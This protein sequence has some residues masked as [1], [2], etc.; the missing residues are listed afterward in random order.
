MNGTKRIRAVHKLYNTGVIASSLSTELQLTLEGR[1]GVPVLRMLIRAGKLCL[2]RW[3]RTEGDKMNAVC[4]L[5]QHRPW[6]A[7]LPT[8]LAASENSTRHGNVSLR[9]QTLTFKPSL[10]PKALQLDHITSNTWTSRVISKCVWFPRDVYWEFHIC[11]TEDTIMRVTLG[12]KRAKYP[13]QV[14]GKQYN[15]SRA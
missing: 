13:K 8:G 10:L 4:L 15:T 1:S 5:Y 14:I 11:P 9:W 2:Q 12:W 6:A 7:L 3:Q